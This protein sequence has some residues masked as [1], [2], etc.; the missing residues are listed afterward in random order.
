MKIYSVNLYLMKYF[1]R[2]FLIVSLSYIFLNIAL[3]ILN[4]WFY[5]AFIFTGPLLI[6]GF[7][8]YFQT[9]H[10]IMRNF[11]I[12]GHFRYLLEGIR[13]EINQ[14][15]IES[16]LDGAPFSREQRSLVY[17]RA[18]DQRD[19]LSFG[20]QR[21]LY[22]IGYEWVNHSLYPK[23][24]DPNSLKISIGG[25]D[26]KK[27]YLSSLLNISAMS[28]G[29]LSKNAI[30]A[31]NAGAKIG[32]FA[33]NTGEGG[34]SPHH[35]SGG[36]DL[37]WQ[38][39]TAY[40]GCRD[41]HGNF[42]PVQFSEKSNLEQVKMIEIKLSQG[43]KPGKGGLLPAKKVSPEI[44]SIRGVPIHEDVISP[45]AHTA[46]SNP[47]EMM[48]FIAHLRE[49][50][51]GKPIGI[52]LCIGYHKE[53][54]SICSAMLKTGIRPDF[55]VVDGGE[56]GTG[57]A[58]LEFSNY[59]GEPG[60]D[61]LVFVRNALVGL[62]LKDDIKIIS[63]G[64]ISNAFNIIKRIALGADACYAARSM[65]LA[66]GCIQALRCDSNM[67]P[68]GVAT[69]NPYLSEGL[70]VKDKKERVANYHNATI[71]NLAQMLGAMG[72]ESINELNPS[73]IHRRV[74]LVQCKSYE[75][76]YDFFSSPVLLEN[77]AP[78]AYQKD[79]DYCQKA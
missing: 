42:D 66:L 70:V 65:M 35:L 51:G 7:Y 15:F 20:T 69:T 77:L 46:F 74:A 19:T 47:T 72:L 57:A 6:I 59:I 43:A 75:E 16:N 24:V 39:G 23:K 73:L 48:N 32:G 4:P 71:K 45:A 5:L 64:K 61:S 1:R 76:I 26:C 68:A 67:C 50:S 21:D 12:I 17:Q 30:Q 25:K 36:G 49:L 38:I 28:Y 29:S 79:W 40:F 56:G 44:A 8:D 60:I 41:T 11:P 31:L 54:F 78:E 33:H 13:P 63:S 3:G 10:A 58:P 34:L 9:K 53:F 62:G 37:I 27:P 14:Y 2:F 22:E 55:I 52:K 18:K